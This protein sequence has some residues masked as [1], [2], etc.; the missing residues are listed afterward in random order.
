M[1]CTMSPSNC[2]NTLKL[3][4][5][6]KERIYTHDLTHCLFFYSTFWCMFLYVCRIS[7]LHI[8]QNSNLFPFSLFCSFWIIH[9]FDTFIP[10]HCTFCSCPTTFK[11][12][13][14]SEYY[15]KKGRGRRK[16][17]DDEMKWDKDGKKE[18]KKI[19]TCWPGSI[20]RGRSTEETDQITAQIRAF[21]WFFECEDW[22]IQL[23]GTEGPLRDQSRWQP[24]VVLE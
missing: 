19:K 21:C 4:K 13:T 3:Q 14:K 11:Q 18:K 9:Q 7:I 2:L 8:I 1:Y 6:S 23:T 24:S 15:T 22:C 16:G 17:N 10:G 20:K 5:S 12:R